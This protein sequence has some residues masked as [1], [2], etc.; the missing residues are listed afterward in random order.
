MNNINNCTSL[1]ETFLT[2]MALTTTTP[3]SVAAGVLAGATG[4]PGILTYFAFI[5]PGS[6]KG[7]S[8]LKTPFYHSICLMVLPIEYLAVVSCA[9]AVLGPMAAARQVCHRQNLD[10]L[11]KRATCLGVGTGTAML[12][13]TASKMISQGTLTAPRVI[14]ACLA[15]GIVAGTVATSA[16]VFLREN[17]ALAFLRENKKQ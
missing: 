10:P 12:A 4:G 6:Y 9:G 5:Q 11:A 3:L 13:Y 15:S 17:S 1:K 14:G 8:L 2:N 7:L 16:L